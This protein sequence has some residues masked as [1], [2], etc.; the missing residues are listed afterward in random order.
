MYI[1]GILCAGFEIDI[2]IIYTDKTIP[3]FI[4]YFP[5]AVFLNHNTLDITLILKALD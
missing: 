5:T 2:S 1:F 3:Y 4:F